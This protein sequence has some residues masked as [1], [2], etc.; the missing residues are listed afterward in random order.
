MTKKKHITIQSLYCSPEDYAKVCSLKTEIIDKPT[1]P[2]LHQTSRFWFFTG[3]KGIVRLQDRDYPVQKGT[4]ISVLP[5]QVSD[6]IQV[7]EPLQYYLL[8][9]YFDNINAVVKNFYNFNGEPVNLMGIIEKHPVGYCNES[10]I[11]IMYLLFQQLEQELDQRNDQEKAAVTDPSS[12][13]TVYVTNKIIDLIL[14]FLKLPKEG[15]ETSVRKM[16]GTIRESDIFHYMFNHMSEKITLEQLSGIFYM[17]ESAISDYIRK[18]TGLSFFDLLNEM[19]IGKTINFLLYTDFTMEELAEILG[20]VDS[21]HICKVFSAKVGMRVNDFRK[22]YCDVA[23][24]CKAD[25]GQNTYEII[26][27]IYRNSQES[28]TPALVSEKFGITKK[29]LNNILLYQVEKNF[30]DFL[31]YLRVN[32]A[33]KLLKNTDRT[34]IDIAVEVGYNNTKTLTRNFLFF[35]NM[36]PGVFR[37]NIELQKDGLDL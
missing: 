29:E 37:Q 24:V 2:L 34:L 1:K 28:L 30:S 5:W 9:Y 33:C 7:D 27:Y 19:R 22:S 4:V 14:T 20:F 25:V 21:S 36:T 32:R 18:T 17:S 3:G 26:R 10:D 16:E 12:L 8:A 35:R 31:N 11:K 23:K 13:Y 15:K 6:I